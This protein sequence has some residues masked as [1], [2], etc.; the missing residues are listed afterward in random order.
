MAN[1]TINDSNASYGVFSSQVT[2]PTT[3]PGVKVA[4]FGLATPEADNRVDLTGA[5]QVELTG[6]TI[7]TITIQRDFTDNIY[8][9]SLDASSAIDI[10]TFQWEDVNPPADYHAYDLYVSSGNANLATLTGQFAFAGTDYVPS[11]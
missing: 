10:I 6:P 4:E 9:A 11:T 2:V 3:S 5:I 7:L 1:N 8:T